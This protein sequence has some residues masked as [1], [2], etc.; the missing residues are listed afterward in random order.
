MP[1][2]QY[3]LWYRMEKAKELLTGTNYTIKQIAKRVGIS[4]RNFERQFKKLVKMTPCEWR[5]K[6][7]Y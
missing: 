4:R 1:V 3:L 6:G 7:Q 2:K 5:N